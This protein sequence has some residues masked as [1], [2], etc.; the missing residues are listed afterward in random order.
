MICR[1]KTHI[2]YTC[3][4]VAASTE[5][6]KEHVIWF[7]NVFRNIIVYRSLHDENNLSDHVT[8]LLT[9]SLSAE[10][11]ENN[12]S[13]L[14]VKRVLWDKATTDNIAHYKHMLDECCAQLKLLLDALYCQDTSCK[15]HSS[16]LNVYFNNIIDMC[17]PSTKKRRIVGWNEGAEPA[18]NGAIRLA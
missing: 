8:V 7:E 14:Y 9:L 18:R 6:I 12:D 11:D 17:I 10:H 5:S 13:R 1:V 3:E 15:I 16:A 4:N 2:I